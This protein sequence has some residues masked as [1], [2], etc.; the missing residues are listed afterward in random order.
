MKSIKKLLSIMLVFAMLMSVAPLQSLADE[1]NEIIS[2]NEE[3]DS[4]KFLPSNQDASGENEN[5]KWSYS[6]KTSTLYI[7]S[8]NATL[9][10]VTVNNKIYLPIYIT[11]ADGN[12][13]FCT[14]DFEHLVIGK[15]VEYFASRVSIIYKNLQTIEFEANSKLTEIV[16]LA[17]YG[18]ENVIFSALPS[19][20]KYVGE[21]AFY[22]SG[23]ESAVFENPDCKIYQSAFCR[24]KNLTEVVLPSNMTS[25]P[26]HIFA[27]TSIRSITIPDSVKTI[28]NYA[29][30]KT[31]LEDV[32]ISKNASLQTIEPY[33]F[34]NCS[35]LTSFTFPKNMN[36][37]RDYAFYND[38]NLKYIIA[39]GYIQPYDKAFSLAEDE[40][41]LSITRIYGD[42]EIGPKWYAE[43]HNIE[44]VPLSDLTDYPDTSDVSS[45]NKGTWANGSWV[46][47]ESTERFLVNGTG[48]LT[49]SFKYSNGTSVNITKFLAGKDLSSLVICEGIT[50]IADDVFFVTDGI[51]TNNISLPSTLTKIGASSFRNIKAN[52]VRINGNI[53]SI[54]ANAFYG[55]T[56][57]AIDLSNCSL[58][59]ISNYAFANCPNLTEV[60]LPNTVTEI[61]EGAFYNTGLT[62]LTLDENIQTI[63]KKAFTNCQSLSEVVVKNK[64]VSIYSDSNK[65]NNAFGF[66]DSGNALQFK[67]KNIPYNLVIN[68]PIGT[69]AF[70]YA[71]DN[72]LTVMSDE[73]NAT[74][75]GYIKETAPIKWHY[76]KDTKTL[77]VEGYN[78]LASAIVGSIS[79][80][81]DG[82]LRYENGEIATD[83][84]VDLLYICSGIKNVNARFESINPKYIHIPNTATTIGYNTFKNC[85]NLTVASI[86][87]SVIYIQNSAFENCRNL[88]RCDIPSSVTDIGNSAFKNC[89]SLKAIDINSVKN[90]KSQAFNTCSALEEIVIPKTVEEIGS[91]AFY[92]CLNVK[93]ITINSD[94]RIGSKAFANMPFCTTVVLNTERENNSWHDCFFHLGFSTTGIEIIIGDDVVNVNFE[95]F[96]NIFNQSKTKITSIHF[97]KSVVNVDN[98][99]D[100]RFIEELT[101]SSE[102][103][104]LYTYEGNVYYDTRLVLANPNIHKVIIKD[105]TTVI[106][107][108]AFWDSIVMQISLPDSVTEIG[109]YAFY[110]CQNL[111]RVNVDDKLR[112]VGDSAFENC[113]SLYS[114]EFPSLANTIG[115]SCFKNCY[116][117]QSVILPNWITKIEP[118]TFYSCES[119]N[120]V[121]VPKLVNTIGE[122]AFAG[123]NLE[124]IFVWKITSTISA[125]WLGF[126]IPNTVIHTIAG[127]KAA[128]FASEHNMECRT[129]ASTISF[130]E[131]CDAQLEED[132]QYVDIC[133]DG[134][135]EIEYL[136][137]YEPD[138]EYDGY[139][140]GVCEFCSE[141]L[142]EIHKEATGHNYVVTAE[143]AP[144]NTTKGVKRYT[145]K[146]CSKTFT[147]YT[148]KL[149]DDET[150]ETHKVTATVVLDNN[151][152]SKNYT[153]IRNADVVIDGE[154]VAKT[155][156]NGSF[157][158]ELETGSYTADIKYSYGFTRTIGIVVEN[159]D[160]NY[161]DNITIVGVDYNKDG[162][163]DDNDLE[164]FSMVMSSSKDDLKYLDYADL[165]ND[166]YI[167]AKDYVI[168]RSFIGTSA[169]TYEY[170]L[171]TIT[172]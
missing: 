83:L 102:N 133:Q 118:Y 84:D 135:G 69:N 94:C 5:C 6:A 81:G 48:K 128:Q 114:F 14:F 1:V 39:Y 167:N 105:G 126:S 38:V 19:T 32:K 78:N 171:V 113:Y 149:S 71:E 11:N 62:A 63:G 88:V 152:K 109:A 50:E 136:T 61:C 162:K 29:F 101:V 98:L 59:S 54:G 138:C 60:K 20:L 86:P 92:N 47:D 125:T 165:N 25:I 12:M 10:S 119:L 140:I 93:K 34:S 141:I 85:S 26:N 153:P 160:I 107:D 75:S 70:K 139:I 142:E 52:K 77:Y 99:P 157:T 120:N 154:V 46:Y 169:D 110:N 44:F 73:E 51:T 79:T 35:N 80:S 166:G 18:L 89:T 163:V 117:L 53:Q 106:D 28:S 13:E 104:H 150:K 144:T 76:F 43:K 41:K 155:D 87:N 116:S 147:E 22:G 15:N 115:N 8:V 132:G 112:K 45:T 143:I 31:P 40:A 65:S 97:G 100:P 23:I 33:A 124:T 2:Q 134:H 66:D 148:D 108:A 67:Y 27:E 137:V 170:P 64:D 129:Y 56:I 72:G 151:G 90:I 123:C 36:L 37:V 55:S 121:V 145:C 122:Y 111:K 172:K 127:S 146:T 3:N 58:T 24:C 156:D 168:I 96:R 130:G 49:S 161:E 91:E 159:K 7:D 82:Y 42:E 74:A 95:G 164:M 68:A 16:G 57:K 4:M 158:L 9:S 131:V 103:K 17:F 30:N 21:H